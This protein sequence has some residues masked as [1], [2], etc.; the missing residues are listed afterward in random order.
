MLG[1]C[2]CVWTFSSYMRTSL[3]VVC[4]LSCPVACGILVPQPGIEPV[5][6]ALEGGSFT[7]GPAGKSPECIFVRIKFNLS[8]D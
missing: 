7:T 8:S 2:C 4:G 3:I 5:F 6:P 1:L